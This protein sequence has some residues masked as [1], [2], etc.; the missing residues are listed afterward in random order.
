MAKEVD[1]VNFWGKSTSEV[2]KHFGFESETNESGV[3]TIVK[4]KAVCRVCKSKLLLDVRMRV[5]IRHYT[6]R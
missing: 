6:V 1:L 2:W 5:T 4:T 3:K